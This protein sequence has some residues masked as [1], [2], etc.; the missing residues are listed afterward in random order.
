MYV[1]CRGIDGVYRSF[2]WIVALRRCI[3]S[4][5]QTCLLDSAILRDYVGTLLSSVYIGFRGS[6]SFR[7]EG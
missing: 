3:Q 4:T 6:R 1:V 5:D 2:I 7:V